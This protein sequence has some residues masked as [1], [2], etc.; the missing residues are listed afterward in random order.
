MSAATADM[1][2]PRR[3]LENFHAKLGKTSHDARE[4]LYLKKMPIGNVA[5]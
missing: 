3:Y 1:V 5:P 2:K 4:Y